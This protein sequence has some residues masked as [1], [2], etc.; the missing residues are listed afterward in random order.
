MSSTTGPIRRKAY[1]KVATDDS[2]P[3]NDTAEK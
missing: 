1:D 3:T 2:I